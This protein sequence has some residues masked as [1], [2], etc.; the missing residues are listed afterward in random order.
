[1]R[2]LGFLDFLFPIQDN[3]SICL[4]LIFLVSIRVHFCVSQT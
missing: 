2:D 4:G 1:M 3:H